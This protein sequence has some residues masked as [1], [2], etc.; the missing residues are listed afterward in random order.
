MR[1]ADR[2]TFCSL[3]L[4]YG[5]NHEKYINQRKKAFE[6]L[7]SYPDLVSHPEVS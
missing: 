2:D 1:E 6:I 4:V 3:F 5:L 7:G